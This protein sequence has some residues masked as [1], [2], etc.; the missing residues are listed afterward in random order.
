MVCR[1]S[2]GGASLVSAGLDVVRPSWQGSP[3]KR[4]SLHGW[5]WL[6]RLGPSGDGKSG[7]GT[8]GFG[9][10]GWG[11]RR[12]TRLGKSG[13]GRQ[14][15]VRR[16][17][18]ALVVVWPPGRRTSCL[19]S[20]W[21]GVVWPPR[22][23]EESPVEVRPVEAGLSRQPWP[24]S[25]RSGASGLVTAR[26]GRRGRASLGVICHGWA[27]RAARAGARRGMVRN[28]SAAVAS[29][30]AVWI[31]GAVSSG[32]VMER[33]GLVRPSWMGAVSQ[34]TCW[35]VEAV[36]VRRRRALF[37]MVRW[38]RVRPSWLVTVR[39]GMER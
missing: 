36:E 18:S 13:L 6:G 26:R 5:V 1:G 38:G 30:G 33:R 17:L 34:V 4:S 24:G 39:R 31:V 9:S 23:G 16:R 27:V 10:R 19:G 20:G 21:N 29:R 8:D 25:D 3:W 12:V 11:R 35:S 37:V 7:R 2:H 15:E 14:G 22:L 28:G 32:Q